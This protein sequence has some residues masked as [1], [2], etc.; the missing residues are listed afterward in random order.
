MT[1]SSITKNSKLIYLFSLFIVQ[2]YN[3]LLLPIITTELNV[4][5]YANYITVFQFIGFSQAILSLVYTGG[6]M[7]FW[8]DLNSI[9]KI[10]YLNTVFVL[11]II[12]FIALSLI[13]SPLIFSK[14]NKFSYFKD[15]QNNQLI[16]M[17]II[18]FIRVINSFLLSF[19]RINI[20]PLEHFYY[21]IIFFLSISIQICLLYYNNEISL[22]NILYI[23]LIS[24]TISSSYLLIRFKKYLK[25][26]FTP[27]LLAKHY[28]FSFTLI[29]SSICFVIFQ[30]LDRFILRINSSSLLFAQYST[31]LSI[32]LISALLVTAIC[33]SDFPYLKKLSII[34]K[35]AMGQI[36]LKMKQSMN[37][38]FLTSVI[39]ISSNDLIIEIFAKNYHTAQTT[40]CLNLLVASNFFRLKY[41]YN[42]NNLFL[43]D[44]NK[45]I[46]VTK[47]FILITGIVLLNIFSNNNPLISFPISFIVTFILAD[48][49]SNFIITSRLFDFSLKD[50]TIFFNGTILILISFTLYFLKS[51]D[52]SNAVFYSLKIFFVFVSLFFLIKMILI[53]QKRQHNG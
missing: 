16:L 34:K 17:I 6:L 28:R 12:V 2:V 43:L 13:G 37:L 29:L 39:L 18:L 51:I 36:R 3:I 38:M 19:F 30:N 33:S 15:I 35:E 40:L 23:F 41:L 11:L 31:A 52:M 14:N 24:E 45:Q 26:D 53:K 32:S 48:I 27:N 44:K 50:L 21:S 5:D 4:I 8:N 42:E 10:K 47:A 46:L 1:F 7:K 22:Q 9:D 49:I 20:K 25:F